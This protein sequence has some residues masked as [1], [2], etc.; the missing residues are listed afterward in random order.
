MERRYVKYNGD[1]DPTSLPAEWHQWLHR[2]RA[3]PPTAEEMVRGQHQ[4]ELFRQRVA[5]LDAE[6]ARRRFREH[7]SCGG[8]GGRG[9]GGGAG[10]EDFIH[11]LESHAAAEASAAGDGGSGGVDSGG[12]G[13]SG[14]SK[15]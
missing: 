10:A 14:A 9:G 7:T 5:E 6:D 8:G 4:R 2:A 3:T 1:I 11:Q 15:P 12:G 13:G